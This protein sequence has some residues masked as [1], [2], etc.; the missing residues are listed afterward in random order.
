MVGFRLPLSTP[1][2][3]RPIEVRDVIQI[4]HSPCIAH[5]QEAAVGP[6][7]LVPDGV[8]CDREIYAAVGNIVVVIRHGHVA[9]YKPFFLLDRVVMDGDEQFEQSAQ[10]AFVIIGRLN[11][12]LQICKAGLAC[13]GIIYSTTD[14]KSWLRSPNSMP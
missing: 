9:D 14:L 1:A 7:Q 6:D 5:P 12:V 4:F 11:T 2:L 8:Q 10:G 3:S 13:P